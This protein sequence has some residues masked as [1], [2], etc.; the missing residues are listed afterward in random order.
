MRDDHGLRLT[1]E[2]RAQPVHRLEMWGRGWGRAA[3]DGALP[4]D[5]PDGSR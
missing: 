2:R 4:I 3:L 5:T 1:I